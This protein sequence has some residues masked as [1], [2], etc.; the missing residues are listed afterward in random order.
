MTE[1]RLLALTVTLDAALEALLLRL[2]PTATTELT[3]DTVV[4][5]LD[6]AVPVFPVEEPAPQAV[7]PTTRK[8]V[9][10][11][12]LNECCKDIPLIRE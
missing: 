9:N 12:K 1:V 5:L 7:K 11:P 10:A 8:H 3:L 2:E 6:T 4:T